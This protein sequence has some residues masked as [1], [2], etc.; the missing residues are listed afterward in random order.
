MKNFI[1]LRWPL[2]FAIWMY[3]FVG[4]VQAVPAAL[5]IQV[6][7][8]FYASV[9]DV[10]VER[11]DGSIQV[12]G[13]LQRQHYQTHHRML[14]GHLDVILVDADG[15]EIYSTVVEYEKSMI[16]QP[17]VDFNFVLEGTFESATNLIIRH[18]VGNH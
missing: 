17:Y 5:S 9:E 11:V 1:N 6:E 15:K 16:N 4:V 14:P 2:V 13:R 12:E 10:R 7:D 18:H 3:A 8:S